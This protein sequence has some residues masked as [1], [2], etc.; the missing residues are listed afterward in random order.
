M[1]ALLT[2]QGTQFGAED[3]AKCPQST[4]DV[5]QVAAADETRTVR[6]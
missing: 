5:A 6:M 4:I 2:T 3:A 1:H